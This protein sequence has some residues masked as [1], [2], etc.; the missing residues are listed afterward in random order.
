[1]VKTASLFSQLLQHIPRTEFASLVKKH[2]TEYASKGFK[3]WTQLVSMLFYHLAD[4][5]WKCGRRE[6]RRSSKTPVA[7]SSSGCRRRRS[8][9]EVVDTIL[10]LSDTAEVILR[11]LKPVLETPY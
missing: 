10:R 7:V 9:G 4:A 1:M 11:H 6:H 3:S 8:P 2:R 5:R